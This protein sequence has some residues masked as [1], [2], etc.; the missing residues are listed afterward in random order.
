M[1][2]AGHVLVWR[3]WSRREA[4]SWAPSRWPCTPYIC[5][6]APVEQRASRGREPVALPLDGRDLL[7]S[8]EAW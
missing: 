1:A 5:A 7:A 6:I 3:I 4:A 8:S 2:H